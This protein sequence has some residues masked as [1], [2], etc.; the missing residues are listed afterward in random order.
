MKI[1]YT[2][3]QLAIY[4][5]WVVIHFGIWAIG[6]GLSFGDKY[7]SRAFWPDDGLDPYSQY[8]VS[9]FLAYAIAPLV[10]FYI[11]QLIQADKA[12]KKEQD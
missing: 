8:D 2:K 10:I 1:K 7:S 12:E 5:G 9:E 4:L 3:T 11:W 6:G